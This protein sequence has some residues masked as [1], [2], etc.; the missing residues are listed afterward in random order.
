MPF[1]VPGTYQAIPNTYAGQEATIIEV[2]PSA[3]MAALPTLKAATVVIQ[4]ADGT[5]ADTGGLP[6]MPTTFAMYLELIPAPTAVA[7]TPNPI[8]A[9]APIVTSPATRSIPLSVPNQEC[10][11]IVT[12]ATSTNGG[13]SHALLEALTKS[14]FQRAV[15][16]VNNGFNEPHFLD[17]RMRNKSNKNIRAIE[18]YAVYANVMG[19][20]GETRI[21]TSQ[22]DKI[23]KPGGEHIGYSYD[24]TT[25]QENGKGDVTVY[26]NR[27]RYDDNTFWQDNG[28]HSCS[29]T[30]R[31]K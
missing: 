6:V 24:T 8:I 31:I 9:A 18:A 16:K 11:V 7:T 3:M 29:L 20:E 2:K 28:S 15:E 10:P 27:I 19:D 14:E 21:I 1:Y 23:I 30:T 4:F 17:I 25:R 22:N 12:K 5:K 13:F 26:V